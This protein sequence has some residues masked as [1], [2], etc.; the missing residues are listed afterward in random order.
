M[1][2]KTPTWVWVVLGIV[3]FCVLAVALLIGGSIVM[4]RSHVHTELAEKQTAE[5]EFARERARFAGQQPLIELKKTSNDD[6]RMIVHHPPEAA[7]RHTDLKAIKVLVY[8][9][10]EGRL[11]HIDVP[12]WLW[13]MIPQD[14]RAGGRRRMTFGGGNVDFDFE[15]GNLTL[16]DVERHGPGLVVDGVDSRGAQV[17][18]WAE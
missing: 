2:S 14:R 17:L 1:A 10:R 15:N 8:D 16:D 4:F 13:R 5:Q 12:L 6:D 11:I 18:V 3:G 9:N 7:E